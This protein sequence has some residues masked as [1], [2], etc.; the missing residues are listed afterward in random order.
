MNNYVVRHQHYNVRVSV[1]NLP[2]VTIGPVVN[3]EEV[4]PSTNVRK[5]ACSELCHLNQGEV[6]TVRI[7]VRDGKTCLYFGDTNDRL[8]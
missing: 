4:S 7:E 3:G 8:N 5:S 1:E 2:Y 6:F